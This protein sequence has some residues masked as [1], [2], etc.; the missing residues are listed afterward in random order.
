MFIIGLS[1]A[2]SHDNKD[3]NVNFLPNNELQWQ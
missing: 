1:K 3:F 2:L